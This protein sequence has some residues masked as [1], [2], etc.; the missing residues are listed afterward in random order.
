MSSPSRHLGL[1]LGGTNIKLT[2]IEIH[3][4]SEPRVVAASSVPTLA[5]DGPDAVTARMVAAGRAFATEHGPVSTVGV[6][7]P[8]LF[9]P[10]TGRIKLFPNLQGSWPGFPLRDRVAHGLG[11]PTMII[12]DAR[13]FVL[14]EAELGAG[15]GSRTLVGLTLGTGIGGGVIIDRRLHLGTT[16]TAGEIGHQTVDPEG[17]MCGCG[18]R[19]CAEVFAQAGTIA[20]LGG[21]A[22]AEA[23]FAGAAD[24][25]ERCR[26][27]VATLVRALAIAIANVVTVL[28]PDVIVI[29]GGMASAYDTLHAPLLA[30][31]RSRAPLVPSDR[32]R[33]VAAEL[34]TA[35]GAIG[36]AL[37]GAELANQAAAVGGKRG[38]RSPRSSPTPGLPSR[39]PT[40]PDE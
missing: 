13:A 38:V 23:V 20:R 37:A 5:D 3:A 14:A 4:G 30:A 28:V 33:I 17:P 35:A 9:N 27:A 11:L 8:G 1:D 32:I 31:V 7:I 12:N 18:N 26:D 2:V 24:G 29:G 40:A 36:A 16:G 21:R 10:D 39:V 6:G 19:G 22:T 34:G 15:R 25:D